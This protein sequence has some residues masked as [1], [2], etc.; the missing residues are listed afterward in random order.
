[1]PPTQAEIE[2]ALATLRAAGHVPASRGYATIED[3]Q[4]FGL[5]Q[6]AWAMLKP[7][8]VERAVM[9]S[10]A[11]ADSYLRGQYRLPL[12][13]WGLELTQA[14]C[15]LAAWDIMSVRGYS[16]EGHDEKLKERADAV[17]EWLKAIAGGSVHLSVVL[18]SS[19]D[20]SATRGGPA[21]GFVTKPL[22]G[23]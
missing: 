18:D 8:M 5:P 7:S 13:S 19:G 2:A 22:R 3:M 20:S 16:P 15:T 4:D 10:S 11:F 21:P 14:V 12:V 17:R 9:A 23:W 6:G 1:M